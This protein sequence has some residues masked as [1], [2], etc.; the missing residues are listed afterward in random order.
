MIVPQNRGCHIR[1]SRSGTVID[2]LSLSQQSQ[3]SIDSSLLVQQHEYKICINL[4][5]LKFNINTW[6]QAVI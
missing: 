1:F 5:Q 3:T 6:K 4:E 2:Y